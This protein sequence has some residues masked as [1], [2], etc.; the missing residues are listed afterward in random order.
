N[1]DAPLGLVF[2]LLGNG[3][4]T[5]RAPVSYGVGPSP[6]AIA[7]GDLNGDGKADLIVGNLPVNSVGVLMGNGDGTFRTAVNYSVGQGPV[8]VVAR[9]VDG[10]GKIDLVT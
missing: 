10:D 1:N 2:V 8:S 9:D 5:F 6:Y 4:G 7:V 3:D